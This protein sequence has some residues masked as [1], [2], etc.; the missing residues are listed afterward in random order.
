[1]GRQTI[2]LHMLRLTCNKAYFLYIDSR[3]ILYP[4]IESD[5]HVSRRQFRLTFPQYR[6]G[7]GNQL[8]LTRDDRCGYVA[9]EMR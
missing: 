1:M 4:K 8:S 5:S 6:E 7:V 3:S 9:Y 2:S